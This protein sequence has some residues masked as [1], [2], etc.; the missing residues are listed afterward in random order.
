MNCV[1][2]SYN[3]KFT[4][5]LVTCL[6]HIEKHLS[7]VPSPHGS[8]WQPM[9]YLDEGSGRCHR[10]SLLWVLRVC[11]HGVSSRRA[12]VQRFDSS[13]GCSGTATTGSEEAS[14][15]PTTDHSTNSA[16]WDIATPLTSG[17]WAAGASRDSP[18]PRSRPPSPYR[19]GSGCPAYP[20]CLL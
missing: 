15:K 1:L 16:S 14:P 13:G 19:S 5:T 10:A 18:S 7:C 17:I 12:Q 9:T 6:R 4:V 2:T 20:V 3:P 11:M 8:H